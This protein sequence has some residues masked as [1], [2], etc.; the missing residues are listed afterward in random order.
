MGPPTPQTL[1]LPFR[2]AGIAGSVDVALGVND[3][4]VTLGCPEWAAGFPWCRAIV[5]PAARGYADVL[6]W[7]QLVDWDVIEGGDGFL[8]DP[9]APLGKVDHPFCFFGYSPTL[10]DA[11]HSDEEMVH[12]EFV[13]H[14]FL[15]GLGPESLAMRFEVDA[16]LGF[17]WSFRVDEGEIAIGELAP[18][19][20]DAWDGHREYLGRAHPRWTFLPGFAA[21]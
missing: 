2:R 5:T 14:S 6:G 8:I 11:P 20:A 16:V 3:D 19:G 4:P 7:V 12:S 18:L 9:F 15:C 13:A 21:G 17:R 10:F 1:A